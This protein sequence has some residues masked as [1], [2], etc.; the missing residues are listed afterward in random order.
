MFNDVQS[1]MLVPER[2]SRLVSD[3][4]SPKAVEEVRRGSARPA[5][6]VHA[7]MCMVHYGKCGNHTI[8]QY[9]CECVAKSMKTG[10]GAEYFSKFNTGFNYV[11]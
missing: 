3:S 6:R 4:G 11:R 7:G 1:A 10:F 2:K 9:A 8:S 5:V